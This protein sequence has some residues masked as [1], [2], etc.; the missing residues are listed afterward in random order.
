MYTPHRSIVYHDYNHGPDTSVTSSWSRKA[1]ELQVRHNDKRRGR[2]MWNDWERRKKRGLRKLI[3]HFPFS[4][5]V[6]G[7]G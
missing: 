7:T 2:G 4:L 6:L 5:S 1:Q 3:V